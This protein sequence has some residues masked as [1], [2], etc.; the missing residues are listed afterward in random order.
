M[1][2]LGLPLV[3]RAGIP[4]ATRADGPL[5][6]PLPDVGRSPLSTGRDERKGHPNGHLPSQLWESHSQVPQHPD[7]YVPGARKR[8]EY[9]PDSGLADVWSWSVAVL[10]TV[11]VA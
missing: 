10:T 11:R 2:W 5:V 4:G 6:S 8:I 1:G 7:P 3:D 9:T